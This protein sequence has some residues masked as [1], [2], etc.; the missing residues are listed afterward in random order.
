MRNKTGLKYSRNPVAR[1]LIFGIG[2][3][4][5][6]PTYDPHLWE[7]RQNN[8]GTVIAITEPITT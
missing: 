1:L 2:V 3:L 4:K 7:G 5:I 6:S 8:R